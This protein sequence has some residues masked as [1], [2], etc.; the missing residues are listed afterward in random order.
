MPNL[1]R[2]RAW[3]SGG[4]VLSPLD[5]NG[6]PSANS[7]RKMISIAAMITR[8]P[9]ATRRMMNLPMASS[10]LSRCDGWPAVPVGT[11][12]HH[13]SSLDADYRQVGVLVEVHADVHELVG[14]GQT[15][16]GPVPQRDQGQVV[17]DRDL[18][19]VLEGLGLILLVLRRLA[20]VEQV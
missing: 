17:A 11:A 5:E 6:S 3:V 9:C 18:L 4:T 14:V 13:V 1:A 7:A 20:L 19:G 2:R 16:L 12:G 10:G 15:V 8:T